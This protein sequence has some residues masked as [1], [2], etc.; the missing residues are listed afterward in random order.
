MT[1]QLKR[2]ETPAERSLREWAAQQPGLS[3]PFLHGALH[4]IIATSGQKSDLERSALR[5][6]G[7]EAPDQLHE[8]AAQAAAE[9]YDLVA[10]D[11][12]LE[13]SV[14][15]DLYTVP[16]LSDDA[17]FEAWLGGLGAVAL[18]DPR[19]FQMVLKAQG[20]LQNG[21]FER[22]AHSGQRQ[23]AEASNEAALKA[24]A[25]DALFLTLLVPER[26][27]PLSDAPVWAELGRLPRPTFEPSQWTLQ[28]REETVLDALS[29][30]HSIWNVY[31]MMAGLNM[32]E[33]LLADDEDEDREEGG[34]VRR[35]GRKIRPNEPCPCGSGKKY[36]KC[37]GAHGAPPLS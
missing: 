4:G 7:I 12:E 36:K 24:L 32:E 8:V 31:R 28:A 3:Y 2:T 35:E 19:P 13:G 5:L 10:T 29:C 21:L 23:V 30:V 22:R 25:E 37:H 18:S 17:V 6:L 16:D 1:F 34:T 26:Y 15:A 14:E 11:E 27:W 20:E 9:L 33:L